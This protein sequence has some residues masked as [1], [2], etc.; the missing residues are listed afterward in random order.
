[1]T[2]GSIAVRI[3]IKTI[4]LGC[5]LCG[6]VGLSESSG[7]M[8]FLFDVFF[9]IVGGIVTLPLLMFI[10]PLVKFSAGLPYN[11]QA[12]TGW[13]F[14]GLFILY[15]LVYMLVAYMASGSFIDFNSPEVSG[16][17]T[18]TFIDLFI[19]VATTRKS[20]YKL[21]EQQNYHD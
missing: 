1:M 12:R 17:M 20:L 15:F 7:L 4:V 16:L 10:S 9:F 13:L 8:A 5:I 18:A 2:H 19:A 11:K 14:V 21:Y 6:M 3:W